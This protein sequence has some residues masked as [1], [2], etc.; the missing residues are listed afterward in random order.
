MGFIVPQLF[1]YKDSF[2]IKYHE[3]W[4]DIKHKNQIKYF[5]SVILIANQ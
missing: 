2:G 4:Y 3:G 5:Q 1:F